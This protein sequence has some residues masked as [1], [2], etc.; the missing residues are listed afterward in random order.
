MP[1]SSSPNVLSLYPVVH[2]LIYFLRIVAR[3][4]WLG[5]AMANEG[6][7][8]QGV[9]SR[10][11]GGVATFEGQGSFSTPFIVRRIDEASWRFLVNLMISRSFPSLA[12]VL[13]CDA[14]LEI[15]RG[16]LL[17]ASLLLGV[18][19]EVA[20][21]TLLDEL[22]SSKGLSKTKGADVLG[23]RFKVKFL[24]E[25]VGLGCEDP[26]Q[27]AI[28]GF[29]ANWAT[30]VC[31]LYKIRNSIAHAGEPLV[32]ESGSMV[33]LTLKHVGSFLF[34]TEALLCWL[35]EERIRAKIQRYATARM[36]PMGYPISGMMAPA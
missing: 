6:T 21:S 31:E 22:A 11:E 33:P 28:K 14:L 7:L 23:K 3:Q 27:I 32:R 4:Y 1:T 17:Q 12:E 13:L 15:R 9:R 20:V 10:I 16:A 26:Q 18:C 35:D 34:A 2:E 30:T 8:V 36:L 25:T 19:C 24:E 5:L 29:A